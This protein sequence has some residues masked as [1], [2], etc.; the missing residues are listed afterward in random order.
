MT[1][2]R[3]EEKRQHLNEREMES[4]LVKESEWADAGYIELE[5]REGDRQ[6][7][8]GPCGKAGEPQVPSNRDASRGRDQT[9]RYLVSCFHE[10]TDGTRMEWNRRDF[11]RVVG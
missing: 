4:P 8:E 9:V 3:E 5:K 6:N 7:D 10:I 2:R 11:Q 1:L